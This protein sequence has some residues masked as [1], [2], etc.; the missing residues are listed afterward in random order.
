MLR[1]R[2]KRFLGLLLLGLVMTGLMGLTGPLAQAQVP[3]PA[4]S[5]SPAPSE[6]LGPPDNV[7]R[8]GNVELA[9]VI[10]DGERLF[11]VVAPTILDRNNLGGRTPVEVR[12]QRIRENLDY[13]LSLKEFSL[14]DNEMEYGTRFDPK[15]LAVGVAPLSGQTVV[16]ASDADH[17]EPQILLT[18][19][20]QDANYY[21]LSRTQL[22]ERWRDRLQT[23]LLDAL[24]SRQPE[25]IAR[26]VW[27]ALIIVL[28]LLLLSLLGF[29][30]VK[31]LN[32][33]RQAL[34]ERQSAAS[35][36]VPPQAPTEGDPDPA[37]LLD[38]PE[39]LKR[40]FD[41]DQRLRWLDLLRWLLIWA[42]VLAWL[43]G[44]AI[45]VEELPLMQ[46]TALEVLLAPLTIVLVWGATGLVNRLADIG[47]NRLM[48]LWRIQGGGGDMQRRSL[49]IT[50]ITNVLK[51]LKTFLVYLL[52]V[53]II[54]ETLGFS[55]QSVLA[56]GAIIGFAVSLASQN[57]IRDLVN[58]FLILLEDQYAIGDVISVDNAAGLVENLNLR[59]T[60]LRNGEGRLIILPNSLIN[61]VENLTRSWARVDH[62]IELALSTDVNKGLQVIR[63]VAQGLY[64]DP[65]WQPLLVEPP[66]VLGVE[67]I[68]STGILI[69]T[70]IKTQ[71]LQ[72]WA[73]GREFRFRLKLALDQENI[74][75]GNVQQLLLH[76]GPEDQEE[77]E[78]VNGDRPQPSSIFKP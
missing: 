34:K 42:G 59:T 21:G 63:D 9:P 35:S 30:G 24:K 26:W 40:Y 64:D 16:A 18:V 45:L 50:T 19:T 41:L 69:R 15:T 54:L 17:P 25:A 66:E 22:A 20:E 57:L 62:T 75:V 2:P 29:V 53:L 23:A 47:I 7:R 74:Y 27:L 38:F 73:V 28:G 11:D 46:V 70:W 61:R 33:R 13:I 39:T 52:A 67:N 76:S 5:P 4:L 32:H 43:V 56:F 8:V 14:L 36:P 68:T 65:K 71:P 48:A 58:G 60:H 49:R 78:G 10:L 51:G 55:T 72:Q 12:A 44:I 77:L 3:L 37:F 6:V 1:F 31:R